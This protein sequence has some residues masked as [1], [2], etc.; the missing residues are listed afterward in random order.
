MTSRCKGKRIGLFGGS[1]D[2]PHLGHQSLVESALQTLS[3]DEVWIIPAGI[4]VHRRLTGEV[5]PEMRLEWVKTVFGDM[6][7]VS[8]KEWESNRATPVAAIETLWRFRQECEDTIPL[9]LCGADSYATLPQWIEYPVHRS[10]CN[11]AVF[12]R[13]GSE[14]PDILDGWKPMSRDRWL[15]MAP[16]GAGHIIRMDRQLPDISATRIRQL[17][18][19]GENLSG[20]VNERIKAEVETH[21][22]GETAYERGD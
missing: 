3:L 22:S 14:M 5:T 6:D 10:L 20:M 18:E 1:F 2:P 21:Y 7:G 8:I 13:A 16:D 11:V 4:P 17:A 19:A 9:W 15:T 12:K